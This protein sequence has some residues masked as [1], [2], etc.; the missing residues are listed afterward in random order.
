MS[1][2]YTNLRR[3]KSFG[4]FLRMNV[5]GETSTLGKRFPGSSGR[6]PWAGNA[7]GVAASYGATKHL[8]DCYDDYE[9]M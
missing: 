2:H 8:E 5:E 7:P 3:P 6:A 1:I 4:D 9:E